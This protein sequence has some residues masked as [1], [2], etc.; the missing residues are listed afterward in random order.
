LG[1]V[2]A[3]AAGIQGLKTTNMAKTIAERLHQ[4]T[5]NGLFL[6][7]ASPGE[8][9]DFGVPFRIMPRWNGNN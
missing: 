4:C 9:L 8:N 2:P 1:S 7:F 5:G 6:I 3:P